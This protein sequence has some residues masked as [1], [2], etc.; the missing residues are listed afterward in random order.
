MHYRRLAGGPAIPTTSLRNKGGSQSGQPPNPRIRLGALPLFRIV[1][2][3]LYSATSAISRT[4]GPHLRAGS[5]L[6]VGSALPRL[7]GN[8]PA[9]HRHSRQCYSLWLRPC[10]LLAAVDVVLSVM[11]AVSAPHGW[12]GRGAGATPKCPY[13]GG[14]SKAR[15]TSHQFGATAHE[16]RP[17]RRQV[18]EGRS[19]SSTRSRNR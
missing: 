6:L 16:G 13:A 12:C 8:D 11:G 4:S 3:P 14:T 2:R 7:C 1:R 15:R 17:S 5:V 10:V 9:A 19:P 18:L